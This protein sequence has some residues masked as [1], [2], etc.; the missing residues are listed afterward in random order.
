MVR[1]VLKLTMY[2]KVNPH[3]MIIKY[4]QAIDYIFFLSFYS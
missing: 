3:I 1:K 2:H 4:K